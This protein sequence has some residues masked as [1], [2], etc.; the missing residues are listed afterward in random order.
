MVFNQ[1]DHNSCQY[2]AGAEY[3][4]EFAAYVEGAGDPG[5]FV[6]LQ[7]LEGKATAKR[8]KF[9]WVAIVGKHLVYSVFALLLSHGKTRKN[10]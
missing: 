10:R 2:N 9:R 4:T 3:F 7:I 8:D 1:P 5:Q 6:A